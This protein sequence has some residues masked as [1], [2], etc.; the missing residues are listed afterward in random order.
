MFRHSMRGPRRILLLLAI[1]LLVLLFFA[2][3]GVSWADSLE[4]AARALAQRVLA[5]LS[6]NPAIALTVRN[7][8]SLSAAEFVGVQRALE[9]E[10]SARGARLLSGT[11]APIGVLVTLS[12]NL[13][14]LLWIAEIRRNESIE[15]VMLP[16]ERRPGS[17]SSASALELRSRLIWEQSEPILDLL[18][19]P[20]LE[21]AKEMVLLGSFA[22]A[23]YRLRGNEW[24]MDQ[25]IALPPEWRGSR[26]HLGLLKAQKPDV[27]AID[28]FPDLHCDLYVK[29]APDLQCADPGL[30]GATHSSPWGGSAGPPPWHSRVELESDG[31]RYIVVTNPDGH[32][33]IYEGNSKLRATVRDWGSLLASLRSGCGRG[34]QLLVT[35]AG[36]WSQLD[37]VTAYEI[38][39]GQ[40]VAVSAPIGFSGPVLA[41]HSTFGGTSAIAV[42]RSIASRRYEVHAIS[43]ACG[44]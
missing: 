42:V 12:E 31:Q 20:G 21:N 44:P 33:R 38:E 23:L 29:T 2:V 18:F 4:D 39:D 14:G 6:A 9:Q 16:V 3:P 26:N 1:I 36:D 8:S 10:F 28:L 41:F 11:P 15:H 32:A 35:R 34:A 30:R 13:E 27:Y 25:R 5:K 43:A 17:G 19:V 40:P 22:V 24:Q 37:A 7:Q